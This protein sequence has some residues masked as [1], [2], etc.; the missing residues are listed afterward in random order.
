MGIISISVLSCLMK[1]KFK[2]LKDVF[3]LSSERCIFKLMSQGYIKGLESPIS[4]GKEANIFSALTD[5]DEPRIVKWYRVMTCDFNRMYD[6]IRVDPRF[7]VK[8]NKRDIVFTWAQREFRNLLLARDAGVRV[9]T[10]FVCLK[11]ILVME[12]IGSDSPAPKLKDSSPKDVKSF[13]SDLIFQL[14]K[15][16]NARLVHGDLSPFN[17]LNFDEK[18]VLIDFSQATT[19]DDPNSKAF[20]IRDVKNIASYFRK[21]GLQ[22]DESEVVESI[23]KL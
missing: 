3:D 8:H 23:T 7:H 19:L 6:Y 14:R 17:I 18:P 2:T 10:P 12:F 11:N 13:F 5:N 20:L 22:V 9:P 4:I 15:L 16:Y 1:E 21:K